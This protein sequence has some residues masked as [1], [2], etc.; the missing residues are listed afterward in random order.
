MPR[1]SR[2]SSATVDRTRIDAHRPTSSD[3]GQLHE[4][5]SKQTDAWCKTC[6]ENCGS[7]TRLPSVIAPR[8]AAGNAA[9]A[10]TLRVRRTLPSPFWV[11]YRNS[12]SRIITGTRS[13]RALG[14]LGRTPAEDS[15]SAPVGQGVLVEGDS[16]HGTAYHL[17][18]SYTVPSRPLP[19]SVV[20][21][22][23]ELG[24]QALL[25]SLRWRFIERSVG[26]RTS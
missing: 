26:P 9:D 23:A 25:A 17:G 16:D 24:C 7:R 20:K 18:I 12:L 5:A 10:R 15:R 6:Q 4:A 21:Q 19:D 3:G 14:V 8:Q 1:S 13:E 22:L 2:R 11:R